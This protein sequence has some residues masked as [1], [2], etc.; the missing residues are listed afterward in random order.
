MGMKAGATVAHLSFYLAEFLG[1]NPIILTGQDLGFVD[2]L[3][4]KPGTAIHD[5]WGVE[6]SRFNSL[7]TKEWERIV[8]SRTILRKI[9]DI[10]G[11][12]MYTE[13]QFFVYLQQ[14]ERDFAASRCHI[15]DATEGGAKKQ[16]VHVMP[17]REAIDEFCNSEFRIQNSEL[18]PW[19]SWH[20]DTDA[21]LV[22]AI[23]ALRLRR[24]SADDMKQTCEATIPLLHQMIEHQSDGHEMNR[25]FTEVD[26]LRAKVGRDPLT[27]EMVCHLNTIGELRR[28]QADLLVK[29]AVK[30][31][32][33]HQKRQL[34][35]D[36]DYVENLK[37]G[38]DRL[39]E[40]LD[41]A[42]VRLDHQRAA[43]AQ[44]KPWPRDLAGATKT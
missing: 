3:Y 43:I 15:I 32:L 6:L 20:C 37:I 36:I 33:D 19:K 44:Q 17:L 24:L 9:P 41:E 38:A 11:H 7:E 10:H 34:L 5:T 26:A 13:E 21:H 22:R 2:G 31:S 16:H 42:L 39:L 27:F 4:Y 1:C 29:T 14:F 28:F 8:R 35:R 18:P 25:L 40:V 30:D 12:P 23:E